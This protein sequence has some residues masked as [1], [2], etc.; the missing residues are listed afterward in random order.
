MTSGYLPIIMNLSFVQLDSIGVG[1]FGDQT[2]RGGRPMLRSTAARIV[3]VQVV[4]KR[5]PA[6]TDTYHHV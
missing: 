1:S 4:C 5:V 6:A 3:F 2:G